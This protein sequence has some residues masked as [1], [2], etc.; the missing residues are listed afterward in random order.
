M[1]GI[2]RRLTKSRF[3]WLALVV[4]V[5][6]GVLVSSIR[7]HWIGDVIGAVLLAILVLMTVATRKVTRK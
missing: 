5:T 6:A 7:P 1:T 3:S 2:W 4:G